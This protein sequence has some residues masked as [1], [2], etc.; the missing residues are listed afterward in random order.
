MSSV[1]NLGT[2]RDMLQR[3]ALARVDNDDRKRKVGIAR[4]I[5]YNKNSAIHN[6]HV[7]AYLQGQSLVPTTVS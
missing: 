7:E 2:P 4:E 3:T 6:D 1:H 5:I